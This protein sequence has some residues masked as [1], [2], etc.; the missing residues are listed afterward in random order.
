MMSAPSK[1]R[2]PAS[3][4]LIFPIRSATKSG[5]TSDGLHALVC[6][7]GTFVLS[8]AQFD[9]LAALLGVDGGLDRAATTRS[10]LETKLRRNFN[11]REMSF[12]GRAGAASSLRME[13]ATAAKVHV[14][15][16]KPEEAVTV[17]RRD[18]PA[19]VRPRHHHLLT[20]CM[21]IFLT[22]NN[23]VKN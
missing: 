12:W 21:K 3:P 4:T 20:V 8:D 7:R 22:H 11:W 6:A 16:R 19:G 2:T 9:K 10:G 15:Q 13:H 18:P 1:F 14:K 17:G 5:V 23:S